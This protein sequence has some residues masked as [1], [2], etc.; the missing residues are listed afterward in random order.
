MADDSSS[1]KSIPLSFSSS[2]AICFGVSKS[3]GIFI[4]GFD[5]KQIHM[6]E[7]NY[8]GSKFS[9]DFP[10]KI[11][12]TKT[13]H[14]IIDNSISEKGYFYDINHM[15]YA[16]MKDVIVNPNTVYQWRR[17]Y[18]RENKAGVCPTLTA[19]MGGGGHNVPI[20]YTLKGIRKLT[21]EECLGFQG[22]PVRDGFCYPDCISQSDKYKQAGNSVTEPLIEKVA[23]KIVDCILL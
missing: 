3:P 6:L 4:V 19:N 5:P 22:F 20:V 9:F 11:K 10:Q 21:P 17:T 14:D 2:S 18:I 1:V 12:L 13:I 15:Y 7:T 8:T 16:R 23:K